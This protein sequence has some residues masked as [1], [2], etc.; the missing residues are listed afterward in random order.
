MPQGCSL[1]ALFGNI[2]L[3]EFDCKMNANDITCIR[4]LDDFIILAPDERS[5][6]RVF[7]KG[8]NILRDS[9]FDAYTTDE[10]NKKAKCNSINE[11][12]DFLGIEI[13]GKTIRPSKIKKEEF[14]NTLKLICKDGIRR[15]FSIRYDKNRN[16]SKLKILT[17]INNKI[18]GWGNQY[19]F[20]ND[21][22]FFNQMDND[23]NEIISYYLNSYRINLKKLDILGKRRHLGV[24]LISESKSRPIFI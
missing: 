15:N 4:Y 11:S 24:N 2:I 12:F 20:C 5:V 13:N 17:K 22:I 9:G 6:R 3:K 8:L 23:I 21:Q 16:Y 1:S 18:L 7:N 14:L 10:S 19:A